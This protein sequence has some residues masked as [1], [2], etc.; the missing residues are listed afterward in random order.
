[1]ERYKDPGGKSGVKAFESG[2]DFIEIQFTNNT[3]YR[4]SYRKPGRIHVE[5][6]KRLAK[7]GQ[8]LATYI[9]RYVRSNFDEKLR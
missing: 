7:H 1:M 8:G 3:L 2:G 5:V 6:M 4:Y 9:N